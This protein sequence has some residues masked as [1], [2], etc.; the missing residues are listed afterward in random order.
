MYG[1]KKLRGRTYSVIISVLLFVS[2][3]EEIVNSELSGDTQGTTYH[4]ILLK[5]QDLSHTKKRIE[6]ILKGVDGTLSSYQENSILSKLNACRDSIQ[7][8]DTTGYFKRCYL[9]ALDVYQKTDGAFDPSVYP[10]VSGWGFFKN[11]ETPL[12]R[13]EVDSILHFVSFE[14]GKLYDIYFFGDSIKLVKYH[15]EFK[16]DFN[17]IAQGLTVDL[18]AEELAQTHTDFFVEIGGEVFVK[19]LNKNRDK[20]RIGIDAPID[21]EFYRQMDTLVHL[22]NSAIATSGNYR[23]FYI[24]DGVKYAHTLDPKTGFPV[25]HDLLSATVIAPS[26][27]EADA[28]AT[29]FM[30]MGKK[31]TLAFQKEHPA[32]H[33]Y[34]IS[35]N[36]KGGFLH[37]ASDGFNAFFKDE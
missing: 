21:D 26:C 17:A 3:G 37:Q 33:A 7:L 6:E 16:M 34:L 32:L 13:T 12:N 1:I 5:D 30:V 14:P 23:K 4:I 8:L 24:K 35:D 9:L 2:C 18:I 36:K 29:A 27:A 31:R 22:T 28:Y 25:D 10:L 20:W 15:P 11:L 19:G